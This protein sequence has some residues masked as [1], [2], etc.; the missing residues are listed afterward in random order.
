MTANAEP[1]TGTAQ[2]VRRF[3]LADPAIAVLLGL[4]LV[5]VIASLLTVLSAT[6][7]VGGQ[8]GSIVVPASR[9]ATAPVSAAT[10]ATQPAYT[11]AVVFARRTGRD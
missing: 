11:G 9:P 4:L 5:S 1:A 8:E 3:G 7:P 6:G 10:S 2:A